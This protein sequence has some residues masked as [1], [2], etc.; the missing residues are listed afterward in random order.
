[1]YCC[2]ICIT[3]GPDQGLTAT[4]VLDMLR[5]VGAP[6]ATDGFVFLFYGLGPAGRWDCRCL[7]MYTH[8]ISAGLKLAADAEPDDYS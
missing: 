4:L 1:M 2:Y 6:I 7:D 5:L 8:S 3:R